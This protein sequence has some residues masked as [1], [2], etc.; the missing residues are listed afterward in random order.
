MNEEPPVGSLLVNGPHWFLHLDDSPAGW[1]GCI[2]CGD[3]MRW[4]WELVLADC[5]GDYEV[6]PQADLT[7]PDP[8]RRLTPRQSARL[9]RERYSDALHQLGEA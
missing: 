2:P 8:A 5:E 9:I 6:H 1:I 7:K 4:D 3:S